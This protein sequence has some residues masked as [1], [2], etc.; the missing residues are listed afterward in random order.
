M[1]SLDFLPQKDLLTNFEKFLLLRI[2]R[3]ELLELLIKDFIKVSLG[4]FYLD[5]PGF[6][7]KLAMKDSTK[8]TPILLILS[9]GADPSNNL[10]SLT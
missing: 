9:Q 2:L 1:T 6:D 4:Q 10:L 5:F 8:F 3:P 7:L